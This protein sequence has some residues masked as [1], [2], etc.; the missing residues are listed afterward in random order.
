[1]R[2]SRRSRDIARS[3]GKLPKGRHAAGE[4]WGASLG[5]L[6]LMTIG[7]MESGKASL[8]RGGVS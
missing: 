3:G 5:L 2:A 7:G 4:P 6:D 8:G 1:M